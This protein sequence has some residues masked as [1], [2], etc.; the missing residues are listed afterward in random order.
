ME[1]QAGFILLPTCPAIGKTHAM[2]SSSIQKQKEG[3]GLC[4]L[5]HMIF[6]ELKCLGETD[7]TIFKAEWQSPM[8]A[9][10]PGIKEMPAFLKIQ[11]ALTYY[12]IHQHPLIQEPFMPVYLTEGFTNQW[13]EERTG[14]RKILG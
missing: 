5:M 11:F 13:M 2:K 4:G 6:R 8:M 14:K 1:E 3:F 9:G 10:S 7:L 12:S